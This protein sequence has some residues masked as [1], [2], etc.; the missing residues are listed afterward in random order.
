MIDRNR[1]SLIAGGLAAAAVWPG[2]GRARAA[3]FEAY[4]FSLGVASGCPLPEGVILWTRLTFPE[5]PPPADPFA[6]LEVIQRAPVDVSWDVAED[7]HFTRPVRSGTVRA[8]QE[9]GHSVHVPVTGLR[10]GRWYFYRF[11]AGDAV[12]PVGRTRTAPAQETMADRLRFAFASCQQYEQGYYAAYR[13]MADEDLDLVVHLGDYIYERSWGGNLVRHHGSGW[14]ARLDEYRARHALYRSDPNL[15]A[16][17][18][19]FPWLV[20]WDDH[21]V[22]NNYG[23][24]DAPDAPAGERF[25]E[26]RRAAYQA[27]YEHMPVPPHGGGDFSEFRIYGQHGFGRLLG[28]T[29]LDVRQ[30]RTPAM[31]GGQGAAQA[32]ANSMLGAEQERWLEETLPGARARW[33]VIAQP[34]LLSE[35]DL[36]QGAGTRYSLD[37]WDGYR[38]SRRHLLDSIEAARLENPLIIGGDLHAYF[39]ADV[40]R[41]FAQPQSE[42]V[43]TEFVTGAISSNAPGQKSLDVA[44]AENPHLKLASREHGYATMTLTPDGGQCDF[45]TIEDRKDPASPASTTYS[46]A[47]TS[48]Q[49]GVNRI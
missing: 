14:P 30:Y 15:Q 18:A 34:T 41:D 3:R 25:L 32:D 42:T 46:F 22:I 13:H 43:A 7:E 20:I 26:Q 45:V 6:P 49:P 47:L 35:R 44:L 24:D 4:P 17:H 12:S 9:F 16:A 36:E 1:R 8:V 29:L 2:I 19:R 28:I 38:A 11:R 40:K 21:E 5:P 10:P 31:V 39:A 23:D 37:G 33:N 27:W 48:G